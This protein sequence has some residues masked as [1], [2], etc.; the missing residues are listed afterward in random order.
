MKIM[1]V[2]AVPETI[3]TGY[4]PQYN[5]P[6]RERG[7]RRLALALGLTQF[8]VNLTRL[9]PGAWAS[10]RHWH[11]HEDEFVYMLDGE[12]V[13]IDDSGERI[14][15]AGDIAGF[16]A[17]VGNGHHLVNRSDAEASYLVVGSRSMDDAV[18]YPDVDLHSPAGRYAPQAG[19]PAFTRKDGSAI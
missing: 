19:Q 4:P 11:S 1:R 13:L 14:L 6:C 7:A 16:P 10:Q 8:G 2:D 9:P 3:G 18:T 15:H 12:L 5:E 17:G